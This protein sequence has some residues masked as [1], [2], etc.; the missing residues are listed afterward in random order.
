M[1]YIAADRFSLKLLF[2]LTGLRRRENT[3]LPR[4]NQRDYNAERLD[5][6]ILLFLRGEI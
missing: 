3:G 2:N 1:G 6:R 4:L 5:R